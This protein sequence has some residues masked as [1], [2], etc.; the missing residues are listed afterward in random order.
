MGRPAANH[1][2]QNTPTTVPVPAL[3]GFGPYPGL[4]FT[5]TILTVLPEIV[6]PPFD[7]LLDTRTPM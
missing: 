5:T 2:G 3:P 6:G 4:T 1:H 7:T